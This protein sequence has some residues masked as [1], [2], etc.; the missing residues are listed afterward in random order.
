MIPIEQIIE[1]NQRLREMLDVA[2]GELEYCAT[3]PHVYDLFETDYCDKC[4]RKEPKE[5]WFEYLKKQ[6][7]IKKSQ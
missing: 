6:C 5:C 4:D 7:T 2:V 3:C 1:S